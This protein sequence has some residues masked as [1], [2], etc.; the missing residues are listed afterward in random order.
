MR[1]AS[2]LSTD[3]DTD[4]AFGECVGQLLPRLSEGA[5]VIWLFLTMHHAGALKRLGSELQRVLGSSHIVGCTC[6]GVL[7]VGRE[8][9]EG[10]AISV[11]AGKMP[12]VQIQAMP[13]SDV[14]WAQAADNPDLARAAIGDPADLQALIVLADPFSTPLVAMLPALNAAYPGTPIVGGMASSATAPRGNQLML[15]D[16]LMQQGA[17]AMTIRGHVHVQTTVSQG[18]R[19]IGW[20][21]VITKA[22]RHVVQQLGGKAALGAL[23]DMVQKL[24]PH[25]QQ[26]IQSQGVLV[27][28]VI[29]EYKPHFGRGDFV[30]R[31]LVGVDPRAGYLAIGDP[32]V[33]VGQTIQFHVRDAQAARDDLLLLLEA[34]RVHGPA[35]GALLFTCNGRGKNLFGQGDVD[36]AMVTDALDSAPLAGFFAAGEIGPIGEA[37]Y[38]HGHTASLM[39][40]RPPHE[41]M[42]DV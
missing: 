15:N 7:G 5:D 34:Q 33:R 11:L 22:R 24:D 13:L 29:N 23:R 28:R 18:A 39:V 26:L 37:S 30:I 9:E 35:A 1:F 25:E 14:N 20:P 17:I 4:A 19:P 16:E 8:I 27:G 41:Q 42:S 6:K 21:L 3:S 12:G 31:G 32:Q 36:A 38:V 2:A 40:F 10:P